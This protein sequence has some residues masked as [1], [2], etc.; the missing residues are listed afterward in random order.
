[1]GERQD[2]QALEAKVTFAFTCC[3]VPET[4]ARSVARALVQAEAE[5]QGGHGITRVGDYVAQ[6]KSRKVDGVARPL[7]TWLKPGHLSIDAMDG[8]AYPAIDL[9]LFEGIKRVQDQGTVA[10]S[11]HRSHH[12][13][14]L[15]YH[16]ARAAE[17]GMVAL[18]V[19]NAPAAMA[20]WGGKTPVFG[21]NPIAFAAPREGDPLVID[22]SLSKVARGKVMA[23][24]KAGEPIPEGWAIT[25]DGAPTTDPDEALAG[26]MLPAGDAKGT[27]L[28][29]MVEVLAA[30]YTGA[31]HASQVGSFF[32]A[33]G[34][35]CDAGQFILLLK[36]TEGFG[37]RLA[38]LL[39]EIEGQEGAR[40][41]GA[42]RAQAIANARQYGIE[43]PAH[44]MATLEHLTS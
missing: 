3:G 6:V 42:R 5:G 39:S 14:A 12:C 37:P 44:H 23:A 13:G 36:P 20:P 2:W 9:A 4:T 10:I 21:T 30:S 33:D 43:V 22:L 25:A 24:K 40:L 32:G 41:P 27:A 15:S 8:F 16:V 31:A 28:A 17:A 38:S 18:M 11:I 35:P 7:A 1:M 29:L 34:Q 19:A 26:S